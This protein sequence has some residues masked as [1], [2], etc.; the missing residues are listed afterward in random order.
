VTHQSIAELNLPFAILA[1][2]SNGASCECRVTRRVKGS[3]AVFLTL[4]QVRLTD[5]LN[6]LCHDGLIDASQRHEIC[7]NCAV[8]YSLSSY[9]RYALS[10]YVVQLQHSCLNEFGVSRE[11]KSVNYG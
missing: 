7:E 3:S 1:A 4:S 11:V 5:S 8:N 9:G 6:S 10:D 2:L